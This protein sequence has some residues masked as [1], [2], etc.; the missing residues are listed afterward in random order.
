MSL[1]MFFCQ[2]GEVLVG[3]SYGCLGLF[4]FYRLL[5]GGLGDFGITWDSKVYNR[6]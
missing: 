2:N 4:E 1:M 5:L 3:F 6:N